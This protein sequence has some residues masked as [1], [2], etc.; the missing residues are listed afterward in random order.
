MKNVSKYKR[1]LKDLDPTAVNLPEETKIFLNESLCPY[2]RGLWGKLKSM[3]NQKR[4]YRFWVTNGT[5]KVKVTENDNPIRVTH[6]CDI[7]S[8]SLNENE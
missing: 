5:L 2:Y 4:I 6:D 3:L 1:K 8:L 7:D